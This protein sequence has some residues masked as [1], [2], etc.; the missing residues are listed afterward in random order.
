MQQNN[1]QNKHTSTQTH[2]HT[3][4]QTHTHAHA[5][6]HTHTHSLNKWSVL[7]AHQHNTFLFRLPSWPTPMR[8]VIALIV[9][10]ALWPW[11]QQTPLALC[12]ARE[13]QT[14]RSQ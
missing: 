14:V 6:T 9:F 11:R 13:A 8:S 2:M 1:A 3:H 7:E 4:T 10:P 12:G 5:H